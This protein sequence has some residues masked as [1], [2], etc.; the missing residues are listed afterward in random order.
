MMTLGKYDTMNL[1]IHACAMTP[2][3]NS[4]SPLRREDGLSLGRATKYA[5]SHQSSKAC[6]GRRKGGAMGGG[7]I[8]CGAGVFSRAR[9]IE[10]QS[11]RK[12]HWGGL[13]DAMGRT[14]MT[15]H[16]ADKRH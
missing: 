1:P 2:D 10:A 11:G 5:L 13:K 9:L 14:T 15:S 16:C 6:M 7:A 4:A 3:G 8:R 12:L